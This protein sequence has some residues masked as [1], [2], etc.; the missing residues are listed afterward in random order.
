MKKIL[1]VS[2]IFLLGNCKHKP[3]YNAFDNEFDI[4]LKDVIKDGCDTMSVGCGWFNLRQKKGRLRNYYQIYINDWNSVNAKGFD[5]FLDTLNINGQKDYD[6]VRLLKIT[7]KNIT[8]LNSELKKYGYIFSNQ[9]TDNYGYRNV[10]I[11]NYKTKDTVQ[12]DILLK[13]E[14]TTNSTIIFRELT[15]W[16]KN[17]VYQ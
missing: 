1:I 4:S 10:E 13:W 5:Y 16:R 11:I 17:N 6:R 3:T 2:I 14:D 8:E 15:Y 12:L 9:K 7:D